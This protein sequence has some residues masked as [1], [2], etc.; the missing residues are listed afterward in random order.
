MST[1]EDPHIAIKYTRS[2][3][4]GVLIFMLRSQSFMQQG[5][6]LVSI[7]VGVGRW[8]VGSKLIATK[9]FGAHSA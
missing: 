5:A 2:A 6:D 8:G 4:A 1:T 7:T 3:T 9:L